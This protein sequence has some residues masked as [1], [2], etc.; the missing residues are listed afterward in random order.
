MTKGTVNDEV[1]TQYKSPKA[2][3]GKVASLTPGGWIWA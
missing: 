1:C 2:A 3:H